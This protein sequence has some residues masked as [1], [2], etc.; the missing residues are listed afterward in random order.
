MELIRISSVPVLTVLVVML[1]IDASALA[2]ALLSWLSWLRLLR[3][4]AD[5][6]PSVTRTPTAGR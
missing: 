1:S 3:R 5:E 2:W 4:L 6:S